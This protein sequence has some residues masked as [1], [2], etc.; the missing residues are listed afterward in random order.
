[1]DHTSTINLTTANA[2]RW[3]FR[4]PWP[5]DS[6]TISL[7]MSLMNLKWP[8][9]QRGNGTFQPLTAFASRWC[10]ISGHEVLGTS[11]GLYQGLPAWDNGSDYQLGA[12]CIVMTGR[13]LGGGTRSHTVDTGPKCA[14][15]AFH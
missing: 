11:S 14:C 13:E 10:N 15:V 8:I 9:S 12:T 2:R 3:A 4:V 1:M 7:N 5:M 6:S